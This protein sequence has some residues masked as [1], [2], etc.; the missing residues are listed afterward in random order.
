MP[1]RF[2]NRTFTPPSVPLSLSLSVS[3]SLFNIHLVE[4]CVC[5]PV[6][7]PLRKYAHGNSSKEEAIRY[8]KKINDYRLNGGC[9]RL[10][11]VSCYNQVKPPAPL[12]E[13]KGEN[14]CCARLI[15][16]R[17]LRNSVKKEAKLVLS[18]RASAGFSDRD[19]TV[20]NWGSEL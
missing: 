7:P 1:E 12:P 9:F 6:L 16:I 8:I 4:S 2:S 20:P 10:S 14:A 19:K 13:K 11:T 18:I 5:F 3:I 15:I 17:L